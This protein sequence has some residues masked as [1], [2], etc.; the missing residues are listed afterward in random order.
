MV[1]KVFKT[2]IYNT[3]YKRGKFMKKAICIVLVMMLVLTACD[4]K[5]ATKSEEELKAEIRAELEAEA[6]Q[7]EEPKEEEKPSENVFILEGTLQ[8]NE[9]PEG[10]GIKL[11]KPI[12]IKRQWN[13]ETY[14]FERVYFSGDEIYN[15]VDRDKFIYDEPF[16]LLSK[17]SVIPVK[18]EFDFSG[19]V[20][21]EGV[22]EDGHIWT[23]K[24]EI[25]EVNGSSELVDKSNEPYPFSVPQASTDIK[26]TDND[27]NANNNENTNNTSV[28]YATDIK[29]GQNIAG[30]KVSEIDY[31]EGHE[32]ILELKGNIDTKGVITGYYNEMYNENKFIFTPA[33]QIM[34]KPISYVVNADSGITNFEGV[35]NVDGLIDEQ[36]QNYILEGNELSVAATITGFR[37]GEK[38]ETEGGQSVSL[39][40]CQIIAD[41]NYIGYVEGGNGKKPSLENETFTTTNQG[42]FYVDYTNYKCVIIP[43]H[44]TVN[45]NKADTVSVDFGGDNTTKLKFTVFGEIQDVKINYIAN[46]GDEGELKDLGT[47]SNSTVEIS[48]SLPNDMSSMIISGKYHE[49]E[50]YY[51]EIK[52]SLDNMRDLSAYDIIVFE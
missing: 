7:K 4:S 30:L 45:S 8:A 10:P 23:D 50:G 31:T 49:G 17:D 18:I 36:T 47:I 46:M 16:I 19:F 25:L 32:L 11:N 40:N 22:I 24:Y 26:D 27:N 6:K 33:S 39:S 15:Y 48:A 35:C 34:D 37:L 42:D 14:T 44:D 28:Y 43:M 13:D 38:V 21:A 2:A 5:E 29:V 20:K 3:S 51:K 9:P 41:E 52:F 1:C 12:K